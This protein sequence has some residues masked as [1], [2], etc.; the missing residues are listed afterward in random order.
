MQKFLLP[1]FIFFLVAGISVTTAADVSSSLGDLTGGFINSVVDLIEALAAI[2]A[3]I[4]NT[5]SG[6]NVS[7]FKTNL[8]KNLMYF[9]IQIIALNYSYSEGRAVRRSKN[10]YQSS[11]HFKCDWIENQLGS[12]PFGF[13]KQFRIV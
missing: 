6:L 10:S 7:Q 13:R 5:F 1:S 9:I 8:F 3:A 11:Q 4:L 12:I 2:P